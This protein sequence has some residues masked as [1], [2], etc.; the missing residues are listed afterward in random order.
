M[1]FRYH[2]TTIVAIFLALALGVVIGS[3][4]VQ[5][6][7]VAK[8]TKDV[9]DL[10]IQFKDKIVTSQDLNK[11]YSSFASAVLRDIRLNGVKVSIIQTGDY[12]ETKDKVRETLEQAGAVVSNTIVVSPGFNTKLEMS[13]A[14]ILQALRDA[15]PTLPLDASAVWQT[16]ASILAHGGQ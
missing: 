12:P 8:Q 2:V 16:V 10:A 15:H 11:R 9:G 5:S 6:A 7:I 1:G 4:F 13:K 3:Q 14:K